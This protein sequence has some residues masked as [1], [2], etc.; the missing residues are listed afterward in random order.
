[1][2]T[3][4]KKW[5]KTLCGSIRQTGLENCNREIQQFFVSKLKPHLKPLKTGKISGNKNEE[6]DWISSDSRTK[7][8]NVS[9]EE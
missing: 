1:M 6:R 7:Q 5:A 4:E 9:K 3:N 2:R 8:K